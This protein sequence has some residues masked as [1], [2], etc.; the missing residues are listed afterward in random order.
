MKVVTS[1]LLTLVLCMVVLPGVSAQTEGDAVIRGAVTNHT[2]GGALP[3]NASVTLQFFEESVWTS[4]YTSTIKN[5]GTFVFTDLEAEVGNNFVTRVDY[6][7]VDYFSEPALLDG[8]VDVG[9]LIFEATDDAALIQVDQAHFFIESDGDMLQIA[10]YYLIGNGGDKTYTGLVDAVTGKSTTVHF[11]PPTDATDLTFDGPGLGERF[12]GDVKRFADTRAVP[13]GNATIDVSF[14]YE[15]SSVPNRVIEV[16]MDIPI[17]SVVIIVS[18]GELGLEGPGLEFSGMMDTQMGP[19]ASYTSGPLAPHETLSFTVVP[20]MEEQVVQPS[21]DAPTAPAIWQRDAGQETGL[22]VIALVV[23]VF[24]A[25]QLWQAPVRLAMPEAAR[26][27]VQQIAEL[28]R[29]Y[30]EGNLVEASYHSQRKTLKR[31]IRVF[32]HTQ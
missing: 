6:S 15:L 13:P 28:D 7:G 2:P 11:I 30:A 24:A 5:D 21:A 29:S 19:A 32:L 12:V 16:I 1:M 25:Y 18:G 22:G 10:E 20:L 23:A 14:K 3:I 8:S 4:I 9:I 17:A 31:R 27:L 26:V